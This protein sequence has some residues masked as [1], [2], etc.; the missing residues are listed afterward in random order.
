MF[1]PADGSYRFPQRCCCCLDRTL[2]LVEEQSSDR[3]GKMEYTVR[4]DL[5]WCP[6]RRDTR[7]NFYAVALGIAVLLAAVAWFVCIAIGVSNEARY[8]AT[9]ATLIVGLPAAVLAI[10]HAIP[11]F[12][13]PGHVAG[14]DPVSTSVDRG[15]AQITFHNRAFGRM[16]RAMQSA[17]F[18]D[19][20]LRELLAD[21]LET[22][23]RMDAV[24]PPTP[25]DPVAHRKVSASIVRTEATRANRGAAS[26]K[27][28]ADAA[29]DILRFVAKECR[30][31]E[32]DLEARFRDGRTQ[33]VAWSAIARASVRQLPVDPPFDGALMLDI[34]PREGTPV[35]ILASTR[36]NY[37]ALPGA[38]VTSVEN[39]RRVLAHVRS[40]NP[41]AELDDA[42]VSFA[43][44]RA[45]QRFERVEDFLAYDAQQ[46]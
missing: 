5:P 1:V 21:E 3:R 11:H 40:Q 15:G 38:S 10:P 36:A 29:F 39:F 45:A 33:Q 37:A 13:R 44:G 26:G 7:R 16:V 20:I 25:P 18:D 35:R 43:S 8:I 32:R 46:A 12:R 24:P 19:P 9:F 2:L 30:F 17:S 6:D 42:T 14:C 31:A 34:V 23:A 4:Y 22:R 28:G 41:A 27:I